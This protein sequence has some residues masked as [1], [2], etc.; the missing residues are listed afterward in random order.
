[1]KLK[2]NIASYSRWLDIQQYL[3]NESVLEAVALVAQ[4][5]RDKADIANDVL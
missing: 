1:M 4:S 3:S 2:P 5:P